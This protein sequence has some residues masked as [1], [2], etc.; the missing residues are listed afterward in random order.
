MCGEG[1]E[2]ESAVFDCPLF[3]NWKIRVVESEVVDHEL[4]EIGPVAYLKL[5][6]L[7]LEEKREEEKEE[8]NKIMKELIESRK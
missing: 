5:S 6:K 7:E 2:Y 3:K 8:D 4:N 1:G